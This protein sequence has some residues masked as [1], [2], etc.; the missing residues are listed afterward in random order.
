MHV[1]VLRNDYILAFCM[2]RK[3]AHLLELFPGNTY[4]FLRA[5]MHGPLAQDNTM[6]KF[7]IHSAVVALVVPLA[8]LQKMKKTW[9]RVRKEE[10]GG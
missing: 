8:R 7:I 2:V 6:C 1:V 9:M 3:Y 5:P 4:T 10:L